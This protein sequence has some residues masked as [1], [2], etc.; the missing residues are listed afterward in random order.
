MTT[1][2]LPTFAVAAFG[3]MGGIFITSN[4]YER[5]NAQILAE[6]NKVVA[7]RI[8]DDS[9]K[10]AEVI[11]ERDALR[12][13][14]AV[15]TTDNNKLLERV[16]IAS[17]PSSKPSGTAVVAYDKYAKCQRLLAESTE[18]LAEGSELLGRVN[19]DKE[20]LSSLIKR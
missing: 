10:L 7:Q 11:S 16:R 4:H 9:K 1:E 8:A 3:F 13:S 20:T 12:N 19:T 15:L 6:N 14:L 5:V 2:L 17:N 18:L